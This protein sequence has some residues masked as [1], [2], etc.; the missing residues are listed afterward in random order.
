[1]DPAEGSVLEMDPWR[2]PDQEGGYFPVCSK[3]VHPDGSKGNELK[4][5]PDFAIGEWI[6]PLFR[7][8][9]CLGVGV[10]SYHWDVRFVDPFIEAR[11][12]ALPEGFLVNGRLELSLFGS[13][14]SYDSS[15]ALTMETFRRSV[16]MRSILPISII[17]TERLTDVI[18]YRLGPL[19]L[20]ADF[21]SEDVNR[22]A[23]SKEGWFV[24]FPR[25]AQRVDKSPALSANDSDKILQIRKQ[26]ETRLQ[27]LRSVLIESVKK[28]RS[29]MN[30]G[31]PAFLDALEKT[32]LTGQDLKLGLTRVGHDWKRCALD[33]VERI[34]TSDRWQAHVGLMSESS[35]L[36][37]LVEHQSLMA[38]MRSH[39]QFHSK[40]YDEAH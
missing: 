6:P 31:L 30:P 3:L 4:P 7:L 39:F 1:V 27:E 34:L 40:H 28:G 17:R 2:A 29:S 10:N 12:H 16:K 25:Y 33:D 19:P 9:E 11:G 22:N 14:Q 8:A 18:H 36:P 15:S 24:K 21:R 23:W 20:D 37:D 5:L 26:I 38:S 35:P 13:F 32:F